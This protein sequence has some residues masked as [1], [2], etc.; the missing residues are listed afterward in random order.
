MFTNKRV[1]APSKP[2]SKKKQRTKPTY[3]LIKGVKPNI[4]GRGLNRKAL[5]YCE[6]GTTLDGGAGTAATYVFSANGLYDPNITGVG[7][8]PTAFDQFMAI[9]GIYTVTKATIKVG[10]W[11]TNTI[12]M[13][14]GVSIQTFPGV[15]TDARVYIEN[16]DCVWTMLE[17]LAGADGASAAGGPSVKF[18]TLE[19][20]VRKQAHTDIFNDIGWSGYASANPSQQKYFHIFA[21]AADGSSNPSAIGFATS[22]DYEVYFR[23]Q[24]INALS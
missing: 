1:R 19:C 10:F 7:H 23:E 18:L 2:A 8:Q 17:P 6:L 15:A 14:V 16:Q 4:D 22:I 13:L 12:P 11:N 3:T 9:Y 21:E 5:T 20:D 24:Q